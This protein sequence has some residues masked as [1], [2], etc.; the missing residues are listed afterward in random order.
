MA[1]S[2]SVWEKMCVCVCLSDSLLVGEGKQAASPARLASASQHLSLHTAKDGHNPTP[3]PHPHAHDVTH[4]S[5]P[6]ANRGIMGA[7]V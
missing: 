2:C 6:P 3:S 4:K 1:C 7:T 5:L